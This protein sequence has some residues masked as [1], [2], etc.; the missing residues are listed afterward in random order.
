MAIEGVGAL[1]Q[2]VDFGMFGSD[3][4]DIAFI[5]GKADLYYSEAHSGEVAL[6]EY[7][8][9]TGETLADNRVVL[10]KNLILKGIVS[11][12]QSFAF[13]IINIASPTRT[14]TAWQ[15]IEDFR[16]QGGPTTVITQLGVYENMDILKAEAIQNADTGKGLDFTITLREV[17]FGK[18]QTVQLAAVDLGEAA[19]QKASDIA[20]GLKQSTIPANTTFLQDI[21]T[22]IAGAFN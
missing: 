18:T 16:Q 2:N 6:T 1:I 11:D 4:T 14:K 22:G 5:A 20:G 12:L 19:K 13:G 8:I 10:P 21:V 15:A 9:E 17:Q 3:P 7:P